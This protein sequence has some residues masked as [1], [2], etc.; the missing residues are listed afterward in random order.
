MEFETFGQ[1]EAEL[2]EQGFLLR[3]GFGDAAQADLA[4]VGGG[5]NDV[6]ALQAWRAAPAPSSATTAAALST[7]LADG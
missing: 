4:S 2:V 1:A 3:R 6:G 5:Q 7:P